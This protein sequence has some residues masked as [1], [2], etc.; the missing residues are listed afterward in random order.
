M[1]GPLT[2]WQWVGR[3]LAIGAALVVIGWVVGL[4]GALWQPWA[5]MVLG[6]LGVFLGG[7]SWAASQLGGAGVAAAFIGFVAALG[8]SLEGHHAVVAG[9]APIVEMT[10]LSAWD[11]RSEVVALRVRELQ[12]LRRYESW[13]TQRRGSGKTASSTSTVVTPL[14]DPAE[15]R[16]VGFH[17]AGTGEG[18]RSN[19][20]W[21]LASA[22]WHGSGPVECG[23]GTKLALAKCA[24]DKVAVADGASERFVEVFATE[25][26]LRGAHSL[27]KVAAI[28]LG[29]LMCY[30]VVVVLLRRRGGRA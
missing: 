7:G 10:A 26:A 22:A 14:F 1:S 5:G 15:Q 11:P 29:F 21:V 24:R 9:T 27:G 17:C 4:V 8:M 30:A 19:G 23:A 28:P 18:R 6:A 20:R 2:P 13:A 3:A 12:H 25:A 16:I